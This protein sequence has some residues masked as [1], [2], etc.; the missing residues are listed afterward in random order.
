[1][2]RKLD[3]RAIEKAARMLKVIGHPLRLK[4]IEGLEEGEMCVNEIQK[5]LGTSQ[6]I[7][8]QQLSI[9]KQQGIVRPQRR[10]N[11]IFYS[12]LT[13]SVLSIL[14]CIRKCSVRRDKGRRGS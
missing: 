1:M 12:I 6:A 4:L 11:K 14:D 8:S 13:R 2:G 9:L 10:G 3:V 7:V 5:T